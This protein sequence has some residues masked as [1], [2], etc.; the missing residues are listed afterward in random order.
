MGNAKY[1]G[2]ST[3]KGDPTLLDWEVEDSN[4]MGRLWHSLEPHV[5]F[6]YLLPVIITNVSYYLISVVAIMFAGHL[7][8]LELAGSILALSWATI[9]GFAFMVGLSGALETLCGQGYGAKLYRLMGIYLQASCIISLFFSILISILWFFSEPILILL[10]QDHQVSQSAALYLKFLIPGL[11]AHGFFQNIM[12]FLQAQSVVMLLVFCSLLPLIAHFGVAYTLVH[13]TPLG[14]KGAALAASISLWIAVIILAGY[15]L[16][17]KKFRKTW[18]GF[19]VVSSNHVFAVL[20]LALSSAA[21]VCLK[22]WAFELLVLLAGLMPQSEIS[23]LLLAMC[24]NTEAIAYMVICGLSMAASTRVS[25]ELGA[26]NPDKA[27]HAMVVT[28]MLS[29]VLT[30]IVVLALAF[31]VARGCGLQ[32]FAVFINLGTLYCIGMPIS[33]FLGFKHNLYAMEIMPRS[34]TCSTSEARLQPDRSLAV[35]EVND[36]EE[37]RE[38]EDRWWNKVVDL[39][40]A[41]NQFLYFLPVIITNASYYLISV[42]AVMF[43]GHLGGLELAGS[44]LALSW[45]S[46]SSTKDSDS[47]LVVTREDY[48]NC[49]TKKPIVKMDRGDSVFKL[50]RSGP[51]YFI[52]GNKTNCQKGQKLIVVV[53]AV[54]IKPV[55]AGAPAPSPE[56]FSPAPSPFHAARPPSPGAPAPTPVRSYAPALMPTAPPPPALMAPTP[57]ALAP[58]AEV[59]APTPGGNTGDMN[60]PAAGRH[61]SAPGFTRSITFM[62]SV[63][64]VLSVCFGI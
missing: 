20:K 61:S 34:S 14:F 11:F 48:D 54:R 19:S 55:S 43:A 44:I 5:E 29:L 53:L 40:E 30:L 39:E 63:T 64:L 47:V 37:E 56:S 62:Q 1:H 17:A 41:K 21:M 3:F 2:S 52:S 35:D 45:A 25:N 38:R 26:G 24:V 58:P 6:S 49:N 22:Y 42:V 16:L 23:T 4:I 9:T 57:S 50:D 28:L 59:V 31:G 15:V 8:D 33:I 27:K 60:S 13:Q 10:H 12:R 32:N 7:G 36:D 46:Y 18:N 51:F